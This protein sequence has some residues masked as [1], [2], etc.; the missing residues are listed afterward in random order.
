MPHVTDNL[1]TGL[2]AVGRRS[3]TCSSTTTSARRYETDW[4]GRFRGR[5]A[6]R[7][8]AADAEQVAAVLARLPRARRGDRAAGRQ[9]RAGRRAAC[10]AAARSSSALARLTELGA[11]RPRRRAG[12]GR[13]RAS[14]SRALQ[15][16][17]RAAGLDAGV[18][19]AARDSATV[20]GL[21]ATNA[22]GTRALRY[23]T[24]RARVAGLQAVLADG[25]IVDR[26]A[27]C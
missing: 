5:G 21:A 22:G 13:A 6:R 10:R 11:G 8:A 7:R 26:P 17:A 1:S 19:F 18:D 23:G 27:A 4:T 15:E 20:G 9:H 14:R 3:A 24:V 2:A 16:H 12:R 25:S